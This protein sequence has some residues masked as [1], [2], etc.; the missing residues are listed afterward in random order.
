M[1]RMIRNSVNHVTGN[2]IFE[3]G[4]PAINQAEFETFHRDVFLLC[5][6]RLGYR[7]IIK[8]LKED[9]ELVKQCA[10]LVSAYLKARAIITYDILDQ[11]PHLPLV[12]QCQRNHWQESWRVLSTRCRWRMQEENCSWLS[13]CFLHLSAHCMYS[14]PWVCLLTSNVIIL[15][16]AV[17]IH[18]RETACLLSSSYHRVHQRLFLHRKARNSCKQTSWVLHVKH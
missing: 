7:E 12:H 10:R 2:F 5:A 4:Y 3:S 16:R 9:Y 14:F 1:R 13:Y 17:N 18:Q 15:E 11:C 8:R 6:K